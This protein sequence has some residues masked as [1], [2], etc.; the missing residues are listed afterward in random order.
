M[1]LLRSLFNCLLSSSFTLNRWDEGID[2]C[3]RS[4]RH[5]CTLTQ[6]SRH[7]FIESVFRTPSPL[8]LLYSALI[9]FAHAAVSSPA[10]ART[11]K[12]RWQFIAYTKIVKM[13]E[14][15][16]WTCNVASTSSASPR[17]ETWDGERKRQSERQ[18]AKI[19]GPYFIMCSKSNIVL[20]QRAVH[21]ITAIF[22][23]YTSVKRSTK[24]FHE[25]MREKKKEER[26]KERKNSSE[27]LLTRQATFLSSFFSLSLLFPVTLIRVSFLP[28]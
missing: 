7:T 28:S 4:K 3:R 16:H 15:I 20:S 2:W 1:L 9:V 12:W 23:V 21:T 5:T 25:K 19:C 8:S 13:Y 18:E 27:L 10:S 14:S 24:S 6:T 26:K 22:L 11:P 17:R